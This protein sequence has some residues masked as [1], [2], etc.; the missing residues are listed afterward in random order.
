M[1]YSDEQ[2]KKY[3]TF[4]KYHIGKDFDKMD[5]QQQTEALQSRDRRFNLL[6]IVNIIALVLFAYWFLGGVTQL[7][8][9]IFYILIVVFALN[10]LSVVYQKKILGEVKQY[11]LSQSG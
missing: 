4:L 1:E 5:K 11:V 3:E 10:M 9:L 2:I 7:P 8:D 6:M